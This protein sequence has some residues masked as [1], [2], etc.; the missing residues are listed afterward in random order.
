M[1]RSRVFRELL[2][3]T[4]AVNALSTKCCPNRTASHHAGS[5]QYA[6]SGLQRRVEQVSGGIRPYGADVCTADDGKTCHRPHGAPK[7]AAAGA[8]GKASEVVKGEESYTKHMICPPSAG[9][10]YFK[11]GSSLVRT[12]MCWDLCART[13][14]ILLHGF[15]AVLRHSCQQHTIIPEAT[16]LLSL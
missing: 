9:V 6:V 10:L 11:F 14:S 8:S 16:V 7:E 15:C 3:R 5:P 13:D 2:T 12:I 4:L 1:S